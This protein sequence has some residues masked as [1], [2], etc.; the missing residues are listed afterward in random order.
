MINADH[1][2]ARLRMMS[3]AELQKFAEMH[4]QDPYMFPLAFNESNVRKQTRMQQGAQQ[5]QPQ[6]P[7][8]EQ[9]LQTMRPQLPEDQGIATLNPDTQ[10]ADGGLIGFA[11]GGQPTTAATYSRPDGS[12]IGSGDIAYAGGGDIRTPWL[13]KNY[14]PDRGS[15][16]NPDALYP[17]ADD[18]T[19]VPVYYDEPQYYDEPPKPPN[20]TKPK[21]QLKNVTP[22]PEFLAA[23]ST[24]TQPSSLSRTSIA[25]PSTGGVER[26]YAKAIKDDPTSVPVYYDEPPKPPNK[27][28]PKMSGSSGL[29]SGR[30]PQLQRF[31]APTLLGGS[32]RPVPPYGG[33]PLTDLKN[34]REYPPDGYVSAPTNLMDDETSSKPAKTSKTLNAPT[35]PAGAIP[36]RSQLKNGTVPPEVLAAASTGTQPSRLPSMSTAQ[37]SRL[38]SMS[39]AQ[40]SRLPSMSIAQPSTGGVERLYA[41]AI[42]D[43]Q[44]IASKRFEEYK[45]GRPG[46]ETFAEEKALLAE[47]KEGYEKQQ[48]MNEGLA[49]LTFASSVVQPGKNALQAIV[50]GAAAGAGQYAKAQGDLK[51]AEK[52][53]K[54]GLAA[55]ARMERAEGRKDYDALQTAK[56]QLFSSVD[57]LRAHSVDAVSKSMDVD[58]EIAARVL[59]NEQSNAAKSMDV[60]K[61]MAARVFMNEQSNATQMGIAQLG[62]ETKSLLR[63]QKSAADFDKMISDNWN[64]QT[65]RLGIRQ[66]NPNITT[67]AAYRDFMY[68]LYGKSLSGQGDRLNPEYSGLNIIGKEQR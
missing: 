8:N 5:G 24:G 7:V 42:K 46:A 34:Y 58:K 41:K 53:R 68:K 16:Y 4:K 11:S 49:W 47:D 60:D 15:D 56:Q 19:S 12:M 21:R 35:L 62:Q 20:K 30:I 18:P 65:T 23:A 28:K 25:Q 6:P 44:D 29:Q 59:M 9:A 37:P 2:T 45:A 38:P 57:R 3:D 63:D 54:A 1:I 40:P 50:E 67:E 31:F 51:K 26:L 22:Q 61:E 43:E 52:E 33:V 39:T 55:L 36:L 27:T 32:T 64:D 14:T 17:Y 13:S 66:T 10:F 48:Q